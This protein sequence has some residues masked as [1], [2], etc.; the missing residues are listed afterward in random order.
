MY[1]QKLQ[2]N[3]RFLISFYSNKNW[4]K[5]VN[6]P[7]RWRYVTIAKTFVLIKTTKV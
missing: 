7:E 4:T 6:M 1:K 3:F 2:P 5:I